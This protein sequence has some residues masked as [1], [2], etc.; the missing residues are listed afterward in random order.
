[1]H[2]QR[3]WTLGVKLALVATPFLLLA[4]LAMAVLVW[5]ST[6]LQG[7]AA[8]VNEAGSMRMQAYRL[9][10]GVHSGHTGT[11]DRQ[12]A[13]FEKSL[14]LLRVGEPGR[15][16]AVPWSPQVS[17]R[18]AAVQQSWPG[19]RARLLLAADGASPVAALDSAATSFVSGIDQLV[20]AIEK[21]LAQWTALMSLLQ[22]VLMALAVFGTAALVYVGN[23]FVLEPL[24]L[25]KEAVRRV[26]GGDLGARVELASTDEFATLA[27]GFNQM[28]D[29]LQTV[30]QDLEQR[31]REKTAQLVDRHERLASL[32]EVTNLV[33]R[34]VTLDELAQGFTSSIASIARADG[35][36]LR[37]S[38]EGNRRY[39]ML[40]AHRLPD[41]MLRAEHCLQAGDCHCGSAAASP[42]ARVIPIRS[43]MPAPLTHC[44]EADFRTVVALPIRLHGRVMGEVDLFFHARYELGNAER[45]LLEALT[46]QLAGAMENLRLGSLDVEAAVS[47]ER[48]LL[49]GELH[50]S[51]AQSLAFLKIQVQ[52]MRDAIA[53]GDATEVANVLEE[54]D[55]G[56]RESYGDVRELLMHFRTRTNGED[57]EPAMQTTLRK[58]EHQA[59]LPSRLTMQGHGLPL[60]PDTQIQVLH[61]IQEALSNVR[62]HARAT[63]VWL[64]VEQQPAWRIEIRDDGV[65]FAPHRD[66]ADETHVGLRIMR[67]RADRLG[68]NLEVLSTMGRGT[69]IVLTLPSK[70]PQAAV[71]PMATASA[72]A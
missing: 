50:D 5:M 55:L 46:V 6:E 71:A 32:Y 57:I 72:V 28:A 25:L 4:T 41:A 51:I 3:H 54:I 2:S 8:A 11:L 63:Q 52:L 20:A 30:Y 58:F 35:V 69:S 12:L 64:D 53:S 39:V 14:T 48:S 49:A 62:K 26:Q 10:I 7:G 31:V 43:G 47:Q 19:Y 23:R 1:M 68:A 38:D 60:A 36:A 15:P 27:S 18:F 33:N 45:S 67:E 16:L 21:R 70:S 44:A 61:I 24:G 37:W 59:G 34:A 40:A 42:T 65:G 66:P 17:E 56:V 29:R 22:L 13:D 9:V